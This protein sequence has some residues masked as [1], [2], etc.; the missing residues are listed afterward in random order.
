MLRDNR[1]GTPQG[2]ILSPLLSNVA[3]TV[4]DEHIAQGPGG[5]ASSQT[6]RAKRRRHRLPNYRLVRYADDWCLMVSGTN[7]D[8]EA[9]REEIAE[10]LSEMSLRLSPEKTLITHI[11]KGLDFLGWRIQRHRKRGSN[12]HYIYTYGLAGKQAVAS[13]FEARCC[14][15]GRPEG[16]EAALTAKFETLF[17]HLDERQRRLAIGAEA[18]SLGHGGI[19]LVARA[20]G[21]R[22]GT[23]SRGVRE[24]ESGQAPLG[25][26]RR[27]GG[28]RKRAVDL[29][30]GLR[31]ALLAL[32]EPDMRGD[33]MSPLRWTV[34]STRHLAAEL[35]RQGHRVSADTVAVLLREEGFSLQ[36]NAK[37][38]EGAQHPDRDAQFRYINEQAKQFQAAG[39]PVVS[40]DTKKKELV[41][42]YKNAGRQWCREGDPVRVRTHDFPD[43][44][45]GKAIPYGIY[46]LAADAGWVSVGTDHDTAAFAVQTLR[47]WW[48]A[49]GRA[50]YPRS[51]RLLI[52]ADAGGSNGYRTRAWKAELAAL[53]LETGLEIAVCHY[54]P[55]TSKWNKVE[56]RLFSHITMNWRGKPLTSHEVIV[57]SIAATTTR[58][59]LTI[60]S[61]LDTA[62]YETGVR[63][64]DRQMAALPLDRHA[65]H[66]DW[67]YSLRP[68][69]YAQ[70]SDVP[71]PFDQPSPDLAW[72]C[73]PA[74]T[75]LPPAEWDALISTLTALHEEQR[76]THLDKRRGHRPRIKGGPLT[77]RRPILTLADRLLAAL[78]H[79]RHGLPQVTVARLFTVTPETIN[80]RIRDIRQLLD[81]AGYTVHPADTRLAALEDLQA[82]AAAAGITCP[83]EI[84]TASY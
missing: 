71:D 10:V 72:L 2:S 34:K 83:S 48:H 4:L 84:K 60:R 7:D 66:G 41:G 33:P 78:L 54:P 14:G 55:G 46:D 73:H 20:A 80:R 30:Q 40:V 19:K 53:A 57:N 79:Y 15:M 24:L 5:P 3:L 65:W 23:V 63:I 11:D 26:V 70:V 76:E 47:R 75:G 37:T 67:N 42:N 29:D 9:L 44:D 35:T 77:G 69:P 31:P 1:A 17:P 59:G 81:T 62:T 43:A 32:V 39:D 82:F 12:Q 52:T 45:L 36:G 6:E 18:R 13:G 22:E 16:I 27:E 74:L 49:V 56:H 50:A 51:G 58:T 21:V 25:R 68:E 38:I 64:G 8:A 28:G 61:E